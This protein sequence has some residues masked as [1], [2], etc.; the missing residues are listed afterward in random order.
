MPGPF[1]GFASAAWVRN[2]I[3]ATVL[4]LMALPLES[5]TMV[6]TLRRP[7]AALLASAVNMGLVPLIAW[8]MSSLASGDLATGLIVTAAAPCTLASAAVWTRRAGGNDAVAILVTILT[9]ATCF[10]TTPFWIL[11]V[12]GKSTSISLNEMIGK[13][14]VL[15]VL[16][17]VI[18]QLMRFSAPVAEFATRRKRLL[19]TWA[20]L[21]IL[22]MV[23]I[24]AVNTHQNL[25]ATPWEELTGWLSFV[26][27]AVLV[28]TV[29]LAAMWSGWLLALAIRLDRADRIAVAISGSQK[30]L[31]VGL[32]VAINYFGGLTLLPMVFY[33][34]GQLVVD[35]IIADIWSRP[36]REHSERP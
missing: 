18:A 1:V 27:L 9:N 34:V 28:V 23:L 5:R 7:Q 26:G 14:G 10:L 12:T 33:H 8:G 17:M 19:S 21:G 4:F 29:H 36:V 16:P 11:T 31:M 6:R 32:F 24:G 2:C 35:T 22:S 20:Q 15:V 3:V 25:S 30:T 13:L